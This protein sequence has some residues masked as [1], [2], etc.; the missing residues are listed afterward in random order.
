MAV[1]VSSAVVALGFALPPFLPVAAIGFGF[2]DD[3]FAF[4]IFPVAV[5]FRVDRR[6][7]GPLTI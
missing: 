2:V 1:S 5:D 6:G 3:A 4:S 7:C